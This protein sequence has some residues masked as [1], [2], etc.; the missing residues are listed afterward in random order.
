MRPVLWIIGGT[1]EGRRLASE[2]VVL[3]ADIFLS[4]ATDYGA[5]LIEDQ[6][7]LTVLT[8]RMDGEAMRGFIRQHRPDCVID[9]THPYAAVV[10]ATVRAACEAE[11]CLCLRLL[12]PTSSTDACIS[13]HD[14][15][16]AVDLLNHVEGNIFLTTGSKN[17]RDFTGVSNYRERIALRILPMESSLQN[18]LALGYKPSQIVC[19]QGPFTRD[20]NVALL[21]KFHC[22]FMVT[23]DSGMAGGFEEKAAAAAAAGA[24]LIVIGRS[25]EEQGSDYAE[26]L[27]YLLD[28]YA[29]HD[30]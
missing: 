30:K 16:E 9:A 6:P 4:V 22:S 2:L 7:N 15:P 27:H 26:V 11:N 24:A 13:V 25:A 10:T 20:L 12:R 1:C 8:G 17:L 28:R 23:K 21:K 3:Q 18:A 5:G 29:F 19:M 14:F